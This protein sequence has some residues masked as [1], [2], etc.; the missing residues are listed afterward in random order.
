MRLARKLNFIVKTSCSSCLQLSADPT[1]TPALNKS[2]VVLG[3]VSS[4]W[5]WYVVV[6]AAFNCYMWVPVITAFLIN[7][8]KKAILEHYCNENQTTTTTI[9]C[10]QQHKEYWLVKI[11][12]RG[13]KML[14]HR[15]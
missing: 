4:H 3:I 14:M 6:A 1:R 8:N 15:S 13:L 9:F 11:T 10:T 12:V 5:I 7:K 2:E